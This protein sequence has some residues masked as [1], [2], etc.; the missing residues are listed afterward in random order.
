MITGVSIHGAVS[1]LSV[2]ADFVIG[3]TALDLSQGERITLLG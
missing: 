3:R 1:D 2:V